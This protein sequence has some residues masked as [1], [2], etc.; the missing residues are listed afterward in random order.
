MKFL[1]AVTESGCTILEA[2][3]LFC[4]HSKGT[5]KGATQNLK[6]KG[7]FFMNPIYIVLFMSVFGAVMAL[8]SNV[9][10]K[11][12]AG[13]E[14]YQTILNDFHNAAVQQ[15]EP[16]ET[17]IAFCGYN[18]CAAITDKRLLIG[19]KKGIHTVNFCS[20]RKLQGMNFSGNKTSH[21]EN[22]LVL[23][24]KAEKKYVIGNHSEGFVP[25]VNALFRAVPNR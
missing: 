19:D 12:R 6:T 13:S 24:I 18:P 10:K 16:G 17:L 21:P 3:A 25:L 9:L 8:V 7:A 20:I 23:E 11:K 15:L 4:D 22:M 5:D 1:L 14:K 2:G